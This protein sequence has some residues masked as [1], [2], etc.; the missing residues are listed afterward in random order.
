MQLTHAIFFKGPHEPT[1]LTWTALFGYLKVRH[2]SVA[3][4]GSFD[5]MLGQLRFLWSHRFILLLFFDSASERQTASTGD[6]P[7]QQAGNLKAYLQ[8]FFARSTGQQKAGV[9]QVL[10]SRGSM[11]VYRICSFYRK[12]LVVFTEPRIEIL[13]ALSFE[14]EFLRGLW[15]Y[16]S[17]LGPVCGCKELVSGCC[18][19]TVIMNLE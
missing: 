14:E 6:K 13:S 3:S 12:V 4:S 5:D 9:S 16:F 17:S 11:S 8:A 15:R 1:V 7:H 19:I 2:A 18:A 10:A